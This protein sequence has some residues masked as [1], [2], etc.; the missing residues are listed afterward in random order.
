MRTLIRWHACRGNRA[1]LDRASLARPASRGPAATC[2]AQQFPAEDGWKPLF[3]GKDLS[4]W[5]FRN[6][7][8]KKVW[9]VCD[10]V[11]LDPVRLRL[12]SLPGGGG[13]SA[14]SV[15]L[16][17][18]DGRGSDIMTADSSPI[19]SSISSSPSP[20]E[21]TREFTTGGSSRSR[22]STASASRSSAGTTA[23]HFTSGPIP[24]ENL[25]K[26]PGEWQSYRHH[27][28]GQEALP[29]L[30]WQDGLPRPGRP[31]RRDRP[32]GVRAAQPGKREQAP[33]PCKSSSGRRTGGTSAT[34]A[35][36]ARGPASMVPT[37]PGR[38]CCKATMAR[39]PIGIS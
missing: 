26:P 17:G 34:S 18:D 4:G 32:R 15:L 36:V 16:C 33:K 30:E 7:R 39:W 27:A 19:T 28:E 3:N 1:R 6:P 38:S 8:A 9:V 22:S 5:T 35:R 14:D 23:A 29:G 10:R 31:L 37:A 25:A 20:R 21:A 12:V 11:R 24:R 13:G 2:R